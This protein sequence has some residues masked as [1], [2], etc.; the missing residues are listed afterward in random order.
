MLDLLD[1]GEERR[2]YLVKATAEPRQ[3]PDVG[4]DG[5]STQ[6]LE[7]VVMDVDTVQPRVA[8]QCLVQVR[9][10]VVDEVGKW[11]RW[12]HAQSNALALGAATWRALIQAMVQ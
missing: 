2:V 8:G 7:Q 3:R 12:V 4:I 9:E 1:R 10:V 11:L 5:G 6:V